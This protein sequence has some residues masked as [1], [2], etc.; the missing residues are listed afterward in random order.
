MLCLPMRHVRGLARHIAKRLC[1]GQLLGLFHQLVPQ[2]TCV[3]E[4][5]LRVRARGRVAPPRGERALERA[6]PVD[7]RRVS[8]ARARRA[9]AEGGRRAVLLDHKAQRV[10]VAVERDPVDLRATTTDRIVVVARVC[11]VYASPWVG[12]RGTAR[13]TRSETPIGGEGQEDTS[14]VRVALFPASSLLS[15]ETAGVSNAPSSSHHPIAANAIDS[16]FHSARTH[17]WR[18]PTTR[19]ASCRP[20]LSA[21]RP[22]P[23]P[24]ARD[25]H[26][27]SGA[28]RTSHP[29]ARESCASA[30]SRPRASRS[31][32]SPPAR[33][34]P[35][36]RRRGAVA[37]GSRGPK[38]RR[39]KD[40]VSN[41]A[42]R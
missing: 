12:R 32:P 40:R 8:P 18:S 29:C 27:P 4:Q 34:L 42:R 31:P 26:P 23:R 1:L 24:A 20:V 22:T 39:E 36:R 15:R 14:L 19:R 17:A 11:V 38:E 28:R 6:D 13:A 10:R 25:S 3:L 33:R 41:D 5:P 16:V 2:Q 30:T 21:R 7:A 35:P 37:R 9:V